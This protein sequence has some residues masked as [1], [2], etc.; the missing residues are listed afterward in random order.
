MPKLISSILIVLYLTA[1]LKPVE[2][3]LNYCFNYNYIVTTLCVNKDKPTLHCNGKC[4][5]VKQ[6][7]KQNHSSKNT[8]T[9]QKIQLENYPI[10][11]VEIFDLEKPLLLIS[12]QKHSYNYT[13][14]YSFL[15][16][17]ILFHPP[18]V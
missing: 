8:K 6:L 3:I 18:K 14:N 1:M 9:T 15:P 17:E 16:K 4:Y 12:K 11:F 13:N 7:N 10:G 5:L 2:P